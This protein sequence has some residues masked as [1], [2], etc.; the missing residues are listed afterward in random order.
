MATQK[1]LTT[2]HNLDEIP[3]FADE[4]DEHEFWSTHQLSDE[5]WD[6]AAPLEPDELPPP[7]TA[8]TPVV[9]RLDGATLERARALARRRH[10]ALQ[11]LLE[12]LV[13][14]YLGEEERRTG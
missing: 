5:L 14:A 9:I 13:A 10:T 4:R 12:K 1:M 6:Q 2:I 8:T 11:T 7:R 3:A